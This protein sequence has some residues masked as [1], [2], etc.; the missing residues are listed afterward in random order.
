MTR[1]RTAGLRL[2]GLL[3]SCS[4]G[5]PTA[6]AEVPDAASRPAAVAVADDAA[7]RQA[8]A[9]APAGRR[10]VL[11]PGRYR[12]GVY[13]RGL[14]GTADRPIV[15]EAADANNPPVFEGGPAGLH[16]SACAHLT[17][18]NLV[19]RGQS[20]NGINIDDGGD[21]AAASHHVTLEGVRV[22]DVG[23]KGN[24]D[25]IKLSGVDDLVIRNCTIEGWGGEGIDMVGCHRALVEG[26]T[27][28]GKPGFS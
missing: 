26:C 3:I 27:L 25:A 14:R 28:R 8:L 6:G 24:R 21:P 15:I 2:A 1:T 18:R 11:A 4:V 20:G 19:V 13:A 9:G 22:S 12:P 10:I 7:L 23:P 16:L 5:S 17:L